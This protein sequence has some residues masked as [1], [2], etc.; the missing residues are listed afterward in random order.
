MIAHYPKSNERAI[1]RVSEDN[2]QWLNPKEEWTKE[3]RRAKRFFH[4]DSAESALVLVKI[5]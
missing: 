5:K 4:Q 3:E 1:M 2:V